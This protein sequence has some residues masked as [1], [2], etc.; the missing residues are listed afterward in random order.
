[1]A[2]P[3][4]Q[5]LGS[6]AVA[7]AIIFAV[8]A[9]AVAQPTNTAAPV[10]PR[11]EISLNPITTTFG[12]LNAEYERRIDDT[13]TW[14]IAGSHFSFYDA[15]YGAVTGLFR[16]YPHAALRGFYI[17]GRVGVH[18]VAADGA[19]GSFLGAGPDIGYNWLLGARQNV[20]IGI[21]FGAMRI[22]GGDL[23]GASFTIPTLR[24]VDVGIAF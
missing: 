23:H 8:S 15:S 7:A 9:S 11:Q 19:A 3:E 10:A 20:G 4:T 24:L 22:F 5:R 12:W 13:K 16:Y 6:F 14:G 18:R 2:A 17:G 21:G 1:M